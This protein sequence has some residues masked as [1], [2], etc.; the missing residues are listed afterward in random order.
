MIV[1]LNGKELSNRIYD[2]LKDNINFI[3]SDV[4]TLVVIQVGNNEA[5]NIYIKNKKK[6]CE[7][8]GI[9]FLHYKFSSDIKF[10]E[11]VETIEK[12]NNN[13]DVTGIIVQKPL[14]DH[15]EGIEQYISPSKDVD[16]FTFE[17]LGKLASGYKNIIPCTPSGILDLFKDYN[18]D[19]KGKNVVIIGRSN[20][21][22]KPMALASLLEDA[23]VT[24]C[25]SKTKNLKFYTT[26]A[27]IIIVAIGKA[28]YLT[29]EYLTSKCFCIIDVGINKDENGKLCG[30][31]D[32]DNIIKFWN[33][34]E[35]SGYNNT[36]FITPVPGGVG[37]LTVASLLA[38][39]LYCY[40]K[41]KEKK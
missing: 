14:P 29:S 6:A 5:S 31:C 1:Q 3:E 41:S 15:L 2:R 19:I 33:E 36:R 37:P 21:V 13:P 17:N 34:L 7:K 27:D 23:T 20:I 35:E 9:N 12:I 32:Y 40:Y 25:H 8:V 39:T 28:K 22:G 18:I 26:N 11:A 10:S 24:I 16:G 4:L 38:N 30:D